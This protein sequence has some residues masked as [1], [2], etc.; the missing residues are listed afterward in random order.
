[1]RQVQASNSF[2]LVS[3]EWYAKYS[4]N[5]VEAHGSRR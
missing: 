1:M 2:E 5:W 3:R 4:A